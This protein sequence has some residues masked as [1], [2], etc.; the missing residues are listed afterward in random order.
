[1]SMRVAVE[2]LESGDDHDRALVERLAQ[3]HRGDLDDARGAVPGIRDHAGLAAGVRP[4]LDAHALDRHRQQRHRDALA[5]G[6]QHVELAGVGD[7]G[8]L[9]REVEQLVGGVAHRAHGDHDVV[10]RLAGLDDALRDA[11]DALGIG[12]ARAAVLLHDEA[13][14][15]T[16]EWRDSGRMTA[17]SSLFERALRIARNPRRRRRCPPSPRPRGSGCRARSP[18]SRCRRGRG[19]RRRRSSRRSGMPVSSASLPHPVRLVDPA[20]G[21]VDAGRPARAHLELG[22]QRLRRR[23]AGRSSS[24]RS[25]PRPSSHRPGRA[26]PS[27]EKVICDPRSSRMGPQVSLS[28]SPSRRGLALDGVERRGLLRRR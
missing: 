19:G 26:W 24:R 17:R 8:D 21:D 13:H 10:A 12:D 15:R 6:E 14:G 9:V 5:G 25:D 22:Q 16:P 11:L 1:M 18:G 4:G 23:H 3:A 27:A 2:T 7:R 28:H 20:P